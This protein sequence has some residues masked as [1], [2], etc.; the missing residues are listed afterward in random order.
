M[1]M[2][3]VHFI[4]VGYGDAAFILQK[5]PDQQQFSMLIDCGGETTGDDDPAGFRITAADYLKTLGIKRIDIVLLSH[6]HLDHAGGMA[7]IAENFAVGELWT[8]YIPDRRHWDKKIPA[9]EDL[10]AGSEN[11]LKSLRI[12]VKA[13]KILESRGT[14][15]RAFTTGFMATCPFGEIR[16]LA[17]NP[18]LFTRQSELLNQSFSGGAANAPLGE[19]DAFINNTSLRAKISFPDAVFLFAGDIYATEWEKEDISRADVVKL[20]HHGHAD[21]LTEA[22]AQKLSAE[23]VVISVSNTR[24]D[25]CPAPQIIDLCERAGS[26]VLFTD[27]IG[28]ADGS[29]D[30]EH[31]SIVFY[32]NGKDLPAPNFK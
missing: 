13:L 26:C 20:P 9:H 14:V 29:H 28:T 32:L 25:L 18:A 17:G 3:E 16:I 12:Y 27:G 8:N 22:I 6:L 21:S 11:L 30:R 1:D 23:Y 24:T 4:N 31:R 15:V 2:T 7:A 10:T 5:G 19:L